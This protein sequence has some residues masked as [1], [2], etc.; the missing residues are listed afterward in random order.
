MTL[1]TSSKKRGAVCF[2]SGLGRGYGE[3]GRAWLTL[4]DLG[5]LFKAGIVVWA[6]EK[7]ETL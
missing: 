3:G 4:E 5:T 6:P 2:T 1:V 7:A